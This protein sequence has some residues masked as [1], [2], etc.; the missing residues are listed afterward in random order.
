VLIGSTVGVE[1]RAAVRPD[2]ATPG[3]PTMPVARPRVGLRPASAV[4]VLAVLVIIGLALA[5][6][7]SHLSDPTDISDEGIRG[8]QLRLMM[9]GFRPVTEIYASQGPL[10]LWIFYPLAALLG[11]DI[12]VGRLTVVLSSLVAIVGVMLLAN[13]FAGRV[14]TLAAALTLAASPVFLENSRLA[15]VEVPSSACTVVAMVLVAQFQGTRKWYWLTAS[16]VLL[17]VGTLA[18]PMA[19]VAAPAA[20]VLL[21]TLNGHTRRPWRRRL[22]DLGLYGLVGCVACTVAVVAIGP[23]AVFDQVVSYRLAARATRGWDFLTNAGIVWQEVG[24]QGAGMLLLAIAGLIASILRRNPVGL[25]AVAWLV[26]T[27]AALLTYSP[28][29]PKHVAYVLPPLA[30]LV[31]AGVAALWVALRDARRGA[32]FWFS[33]ATAILTGGLLV[34]SLPSLLADD[35]ALIER[36]VSS[37]LARYGDDL[38]II[39]AATQPG[40]FIVMDDAYPAMLSG[41]LTPPWLADLSWNRILARALMPDDAIDATRMYNSRVLS[42]QDDHL[43]QLSRYVAWADREYVLVK[44]YAQRRPVRFRRV[45]VSR[46]VDRA[47]VL[48]AL[49][50]AIASPTDV[51]IG[52]ADLLGYTIERRDLKAGSRADLTLLWQARQDAPSEHA[53]VIRLRDSKGNVAQES[54]WKVGDG[55][56]ELQ[57]WRAGDWQS[58]TLRL[59]IDDVPPGTYHLTLALV[60][61]RGGPALVSVRSGDARAAAAD[62]LDLGEVAVIR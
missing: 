39:A 26:A 27:L 58:Q 54:Q 19:M 2:G 48:S 13:R 29:W 1:V 62:E 35:R 12:V 42:I 31:G 18:K 9:A 44:S 21:L 41:R 43:G 52:P 24:R 51:T 14:G 53:L 32:A 36:H 3:R 8:M 46:D 47:P 20:A 33:A 17:A 40:D 25:A 30:L 49:R 7:V 6:R 4:Y 11:P 37:D 59:L 15:F 61:P 16:A 28:L 56:Q 55:G 10:S 38:R 57:T 60:S 5:L 34:W 22:A 45:Y 50:A 23:S